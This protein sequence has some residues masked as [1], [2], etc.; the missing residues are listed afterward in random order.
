MDPNTHQYLHFSLELISFISNIVLAGIAIAAL[1]QITLAKRSLETARS[2]IEL[3][4]KREAVTL[5]ADK[6]AKFAEDI[7]PKCNV[8]FRALMSAGISID[9]WP[10]QNT[11]FDESS[12]KDWDTARKWEEQLRASK[13]V[14]SATRVLNQLES[15]AMYFAKGAADEQV[16]YS[17]VG[18]IFRNYV[19][20]LAPHLV[21]LRILSLGSKDIT[22]ASGP[23]QN[24]VT[25][26]EVWL[27]RAR[28]ETLQQE[29]TRITS[30]LSGILTSDILPIG[31]KS[32]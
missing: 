3:R 6:V 5:A 9:K 23:F 18:A 2:D 8:E 16:A 29:A 1:Y 26:Y 22:T 27:S 28:K 4:S 15:F 19:D 12:F 30:E 21:S 10:L 32:Q 25:L 20:R 11:L 7:I 14:D 24:V 31:T 17:A 13:Q